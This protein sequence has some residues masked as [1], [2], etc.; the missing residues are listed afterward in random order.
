MNRNRLILLCMLMLAVVMPQGKAAQ[1]VRAESQSATVGAAEL[2]TT[3]QQQAVM[4]SATVQSQP[5]RITL[6]WPYDSSATNYTIRRKALE[7][8]N[9]GKLACFGREHYQLRRQ[10]SKCWRRVRV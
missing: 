8:L 10:F 5:P 4:V 3:S 6:T 1:Q 9:L 2:T 7:S